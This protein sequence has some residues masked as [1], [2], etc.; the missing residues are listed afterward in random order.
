MNIYDIAI[1]NNKEL[2]AVINKHVK[3]ILTLETE[4]IHKNILKELRSKHSFSDIQIYQDNKDSMTI[5][6]KNQ[7][8][9]L[10]INNLVSLIDLQYKFLI[11]NIMITK[12]Q[13]KIKSFILNSENGFTAFS[14]ELKINQQNNI[15]VLR[16]IDHTKGEFEFNPPQQ[17]RNNPR[18][19]IVKELLTAVEEYKVDFTK[20][21]FKDSNYIKE[22][23]NIFEIELL[24]NDS[25]ILSDFIHDSGIL[26]YLENYDFKVTKKYS[27]IE[28][29][30]NFKT[31][32]FKRRNL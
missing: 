13:V 26:G 20:I 25:K 8:F 27:V 6:N 3:H 31:N 15:Q 21:M 32:I 4:T 7:N 11:N 29:I 28:K 23:N 22:I 1:E 16:L 30:N 10:T 5:N 9:S 17:V 14:Y 19:L 2:I 24:K 12:E 18:D